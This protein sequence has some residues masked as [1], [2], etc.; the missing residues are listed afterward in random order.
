MDLA[1]WSVRGSGTS[2]TIFRRTLSSS[3][4]PRRATTRRSTSGTTRSS[5]GKLR[6]AEEAAARRLLLG[7]GL[8]KGAGPLLDVGRGLPRGARG[9]EIHACGI[10]GAQAVIEH[11]ELELDVGL[12]AV[13]QQQPLE[14]GDR[15]LHVAHLDGKLGEP[16][17]RG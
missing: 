16:G 5:S 1:W 17:E 3:S 14:R 2:S 4:S 11:A 13:D 9:L 15:A 10:D 6:L 7:E 8:E 12:I